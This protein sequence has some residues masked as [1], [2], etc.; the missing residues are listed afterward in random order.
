MSQFDFGNI[1]PYVVDG[2]QLAGDLNQWRDALYSKHRGAVRPSYVVPGVD[3]INDAA[4]AAAW[5]WG[6]YSGAAKG[7]LPLFSIDTVA[8]VVALGVGMQ[9]VTTD[10]DD[11]T[12]AVATTEFVQAAIQAAL[13]NVVGLT[14]PTG[15][16]VDIVGSLAAAPTGWGFGIPGTVG[17]AG[18]GAPVR[19]NPDCHQLVVHLSNRPSGTEAAA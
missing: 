16:I 12:P 4:G 2:V 1:D 6:F 10:P 11:S 19:A 14:F 8:G 7:D 9:A 15:T 5:S 13:Q 17:D 3:W 18:S